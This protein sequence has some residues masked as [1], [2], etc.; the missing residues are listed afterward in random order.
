MSSNTDFNA[1]LSFKFK[2]PHGF[3]TAKDEPMLRFY[4]F[5]CIFYMSLAFIWTIFSVL[6]WNSLL[7]IQFWIMAVILLGLLEKA[8]FYFEYHQANEYGSSSLELALIAE[9][10]SCVKRTLSR[11]LVIIVSLGFGITKSRLGDEINVRISVISILYFV[12][13]S[14]ESYLRLIQSQDNDESKQLILAAVPL[15]LIDSLICWWIFT[16]LINT[17][18][19]LKLR[20]N[21][22]K[23]EF[24]KHFQNVLIFGVAMSVIFMLYS[25]RMHKVTE[26]SWKN[27]YIDYAFWHVL[28]SIL[29]SVIAFLWRPN[30]NNQK[31]AYVPSC[32][33]GM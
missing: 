33:D 24:Y 29:L 7:R 8:C 22:I 6:H 16:S 3:L 20:R 2:G 5:M 11:I 28:F 26:C 9:I 21:I 31:Y 4:A 12:M 14:I 13:A 15:A 19:A 17:I 25:I 1:S 18:R 32:E 10:V 27:L 30:Q 23:L